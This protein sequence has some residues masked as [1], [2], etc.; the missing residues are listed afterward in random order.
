MQFEI[1][2]HEFFDVTVTY[3]VKGEDIEEALAMIMNHETDYDD[4]EFDGED[5]IVGAIRIDGEEVEHHDDHHVSDTAEEAIS[6]VGYLAEEL[7]ADELANF[8][9]IIRKYPDGK[10]QTR[11]YW[12]KK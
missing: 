4:S 5:V 11:L 9:A 2:T 6:R 12:S 3:H 8:T 1:E 10:Y 7:K